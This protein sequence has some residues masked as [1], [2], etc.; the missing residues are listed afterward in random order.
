MNF[1]IWAKFFF[2]YENYLFYSPI[3]RAW[4]LLF[5]GLLSYIRPKLNLRINNIYVLIFIGIFLFIPKKVNFI[6]ALLPLV[7]ILV[8]TE[9]V[10]SENII[11]KILT[12]IGNIS[13]SLYLIHQ[14]I[15]AGIRNHNYFSTP[16][17]LNY[18]NLNSNF[19]NFLLIMLIYIIS[20]LN[21]KFI[22]QKFRYHIKGRNTFTKFIIGSSVFFSLLFSF[23]EFAYKNLR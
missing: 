7:S 10:A 2:S 21:F 20:V 6:V 1:L 18:I 22:E 12:H 13:F 19:N 5:G 15:L 8:L 17:G 3:T 14:P 9:K 11:A 16:S 23:D 4:Q